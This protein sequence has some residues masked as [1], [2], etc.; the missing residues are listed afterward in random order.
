METCSTIILASQ[1]SRRRYLMKQ[2]GI[3]FR[4][5]PSRCEE[6]IDPALSPADCVAQLALQKASDIASLHPDAWVIG[7][8]TIVVIDGTILGKPSSKAEAKTML[9]R[10]SGRTH[11]V[12]TGFALVN[13]AGERTIGRTV[14]TDV[15]FKPLSDDEIAWYIGTDEPFDKAGAYALQGIG[16]FMIKAVHG[17][18]TNVIGLPI[19]E[20]IETLAHE[21]LIR[22]SHIP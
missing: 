14:S 2:A 17:S 20:L 10:L 18:Y 3:E 5:I 8:D 9:R 1:S 13:Q 4:V 22:F 16:A 19:C 21:G 15:L 11:Q 7:A 12:L 6:H